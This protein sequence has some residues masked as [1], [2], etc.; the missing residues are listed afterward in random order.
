MQILKVGSRVSSHFR[1]SAILA[2][3]TDGIVLLRSAV[4]LSSVYQLNTKMQAD[5]DMW[6]L[7]ESKS[8][9]DNPWA[10]LRPPP[11]APFLFR[12][13]VF[14]THAID[15]CREL[16]GPDATLTTLGANTSWPGQTEPQPVHR[17]VP[18]GPID[19]C[20]G[21][22]I[23]I[24]LVDFTV[25]NGA[26]MIYPG[27]HTIPVEGRGITEE[28]IASQASRPP[29]QT[30]DMTRGDLVIRDLRLWHHGMPNLTASERRIMLAMVVIN[31]HYRGA[32]ESGFKGFEAEEGTQEFFTHPDLSA[33]VQF[34]SDVDYWHGVHS[35]PKTDLFMEY[36]WRMAKNR[37]K[38]RK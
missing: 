38:K 33:S 19:A 2:M 27:T 24:P 35:L 26:T 28:M 15:V 13:I 3:R 12:D 32:D 16:L 9:K 5:L 1:D 29:L 17:D 10:S 20:P 14:N 6:Q 18:S 37:K 8:R 7:E 34:V 21:I 30:T 11:F 36:R 22:V 31:P 4:S 23:N 25:E